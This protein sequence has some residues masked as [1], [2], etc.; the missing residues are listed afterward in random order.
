MINFT[1]FDPTPIR[2]QHQFIYDFFNETQW[3]K[4]VHEFLLSG[5]VG[6]AKSS[7]LA[8][9]A[10][11]ECLEHKNNRGLLGRL[12]LPDLKK[13]LFTSVLEMLEGS[14]L[15]EGSDYQYTETTASFYFPKT[16]SELIAG[17]W[18]D[19]RFKKFRSLQL[20]FAL[21]EELT[22][23]NK[24][25]SEAYQEI[26]M[27]VGRLNH[28]PRQFMLSATN[29][30]DPSEW[31]YKK[32]IE[33]PTELQHIYYSITEDNPFLPATYIDR[34]K[35]SLDPL[36]AERMLYGKWISINKDKVYHSYDQNINYR[37]Y[38]YEVNYRYPINLSFDFNIADGKPMSAAFY[39]YINDTFHIF[40]ECVV[41]GAR[42]EDICLEAYEKGIIKEGSSLVIKGDA[43]GKHRDT[44]S[45][46][47][48]YQI[49]ENFFKPLPGIIYK[50]EVP[51]SNP[52]IRTRH[53]RVN[54]YCKNLKG[55]SRLF[56]YK[57][58]PTANEGMKLTALKKGADYIEDDSPSYQHITT[59]IG[60]G[61]VYDTNKS[62]AVVEFVSPRKG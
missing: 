28:I 9:L 49:I 60:Y 12:S 59:A 40:D 13:T 45:Q 1:T 37:N 5:A 34:L 44:R 25:Q 32:I 2:W 11:N 24:E 47:S 41:H 16:N 3:D 6:S 36:M 27:R 55:E 33:K 52:P 31:V 50:R 61:V 18:A 58:A 39:Q 22:E 35:K 7:V 30:G 54:A 26:S 46:L 17:T 15:K 62:N 23:N 56:V 29:P 20:G 57:D 10:I 48:D 53:N 14:D 42:T 4:G 21:I 19:K 43:T 51:S 38:S 8:W